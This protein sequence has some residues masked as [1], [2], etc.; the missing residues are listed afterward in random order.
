MTHPVLTS[1]HT[2]SDDVIAAAAFSLPSS[3]PTA[4]SAPARGAALLLGIAPAILASIE[5]GASPVGA[6]LLRARLTT[7]LQDTLPRERAACNRYWAEVGAIVDGLDDANQDL[8]TR[9]GEE[10]A[11]IR[12]RIALLR[13]TI[14]TVTGAIARSEKGDTTRPSRFHA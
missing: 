2:S 1:T 10:Y 14:A 7:E 3:A 4:V 8:T 6:R 11:I 5:A 13:D 9:L 12:D